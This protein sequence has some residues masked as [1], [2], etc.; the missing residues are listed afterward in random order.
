MGVTEVVRGG[1][2]LLSTARQILL[3]RALGG[4]EV[5]GGGGGGAGEDTHLQGDIE[6]N[7]EREKVTKTLTQT[8]PHTQ[9]Q[10]HFQTLS[11]TALSPI[12]PYSSLSSPS[13]SLHLLSSTKPSITP[14]PS[15]FP[16]SIPSF[17][18]CDLVRDPATEK[19]IAKRNQTTQDPSECERTG[20][21]TV[22]S[23]D[24]DNGNTT[25]EMSENENETSTQIYSTQGSPNVS[26]FTGDNLKLNDQKTPH[27]LPIATPA[28]SS[29]VVPEKMGTNSDMFTLR[30]L[31]ENGYTPDQIR[32]EILGLNC[33][34]D[35][36]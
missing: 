1:D 21:S 29:T 34:T 12:P 17:Y 32:T 23:C 26:T 20:E 5:G 31:R 33:D 10:T 9:T 27:T 25:T 16:F 2:L 7:M 11:D 13:S 15:R 6:T 18:H 36:D 24:R 8:L 28:T 35:Y 19:R 3:H 14:S 4:V 22:R 30:Y